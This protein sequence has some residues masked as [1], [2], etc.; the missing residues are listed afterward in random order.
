M[1]TAG[2]LPRPGPGYMMIAA[3]PWA[4]YSDTDT[5]PHCGVLLS[6]HLITIYSLNT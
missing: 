5:L 4:R 6:G 1:F 3:M 2:Y